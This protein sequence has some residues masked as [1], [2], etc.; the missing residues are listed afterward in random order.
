MSPAL[1]DSLKPTVVQTR[2]FTEIPG[3]DAS[4][5]PKNIRHILLFVKNIVVLARPRNKSNSGILL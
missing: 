2:I 4:V 1:L 5:I 3:G